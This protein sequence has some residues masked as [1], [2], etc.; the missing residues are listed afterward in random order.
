[1][2]TE[3][4]HNHIKEHDKKWQNRAHTTAKQ[5]YIADSKFSEK[6]VNPEMREPLGHST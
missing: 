1:M 2:T 4:K 6:F 5:G 3:P